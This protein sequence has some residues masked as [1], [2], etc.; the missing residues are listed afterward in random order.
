MLSTFTMGLS[1]DCAAGCGSCAARHSMLRASSNSPAYRENMRSRFLNISTGRDS[2]AKTEIRA[3]CFRECD[4]D[5]GPQPRLLDWVHHHWT[6]RRF[7][8]PVT[9]CE[10]S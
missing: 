7:G 1:K 9:K 6:I 2:L 8:L 10:V 3:W 5:P 4:R